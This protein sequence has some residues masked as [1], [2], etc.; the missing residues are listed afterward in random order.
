VP[1]TLAVITGAYI[2][3]VLFAVIW[4]AKPFDVFVWSGVIGTLI[5]LVVYVMAT[6]G[7]IRVLFFSGQKIVRTW[8]IVIPILSLAVLG[9]VIYRNLVPYPTGP[10]AKEPVIFIAWIAVGVV[11][12]LLRPGVARRAGQM[13]TAEE[14][15]S[16]S[17]A[18]EEAAAGPAVT[19]R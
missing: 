17:A 13:L 2:G 3:I 11:Y 9:Y 5:L 1:A 15:L 14:G 16:R 18:K 12:I 10:N 6:V 4:N 19:G 8:E 7:A